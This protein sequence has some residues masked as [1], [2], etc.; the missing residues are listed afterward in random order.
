VDLGHL[1]GSADAEYVDGIDVVFI[2]RRPKIGGVV[3]VGWYRNARVYRS[4]RNG[5][6]TKPYLVRARVADCTLV[7][8]I[9]RRTIIP[10]TAA[11]GP[12]SPSLWYGTPNSIREARLL[13]LGRSKA[14]PA[15]SHARKVDVRRRLEVERRAINTVSTAFSER[16]YRVTSVESDKCG[17]DL[18]ATDR[19][20]TLRIEVKGSASRSF[21]PE[22]TPNEFAM[23]TK[24][25][26]TY[27][28]CLVTNALSAPMLH[29][30]R[31][32]PAFDRWLE[33]DGI[34]RLDVEERPGARIHF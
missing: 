21:V 23:F 2:A 20:E 8:V 17:W 18:E 30:F 19:F 32:S 4:M 9:E 11:S 15:T 33:R 34:R 29:E 16:G 12:R 3:I 26:E 6:G 1:G 10:V 28:L 25:R 13:L 22:L 7:D 27:R 24:H 5:N 31:F 14:A